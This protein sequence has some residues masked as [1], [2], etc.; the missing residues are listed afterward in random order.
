MLTTGQIFGVCFLI[1]GSFLFGYTR[2]KEAER[3]NLLEF[4]LTHMFQ[5]AQDMADGHKNS[6]DLDETE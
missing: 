4:V 5:T 3:R 2:G 1:L 6:S